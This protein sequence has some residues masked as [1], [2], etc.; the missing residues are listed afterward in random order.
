MNLH[1]SV[2]EYLGQ[3][4][5]GS[6][7]FGVKKSIYVLFGVKSQEMSVLVQTNFFFFLQGFRNSVTVPGSS[8]ED[9]VSL[10]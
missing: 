5:L 2:Q 10:L 8:A 1:H 3:Y 9:Q 6:E 7:H 4:I